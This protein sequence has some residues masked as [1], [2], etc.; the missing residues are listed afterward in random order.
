MLGNPKATIAL[1]DNGAD[2]TVSDS[3]GVCPLHWLFMFPD[4]VIPAMAKRL[5]IQKDAKVSSKESFQK[6]FNTSFA[7]NYEAA[8]NTAW[9]HMRIRLESS[10]I[11]GWGNAMGDENRGWLNEFQAARDTFL[12]K[13]RDK[14]KESFN[15]SWNEI[16][17]EP[18]MKEFNTIFED[19]LPAAAKKSNIS[20]TTKFSFSIDPQLPIGLTGTPLAFATMARSAPTVRALLDLGASPHCS[21]H[22]CSPGPCCRASAWY[23]AC[24][25]HMTDI[26]RIFIENNTLDNVNKLGPGSEFDKPLDKLQAMFA[27]FKFS[28]EAIY[29]ETKATQLFHHGAMTRDAAKETAKIL[30]HHFLPHVES[31]ATYDLNECQVEMDVDA[32]KSVTLPRILEQLCHPTIRSGNI[33]AIHTILSII[34]EY[35]QD[36]PFKREDLDNLFFLCTDVACSSSFSW[37]DTLAVLQVGLDLGVDIDCSRDTPFT[38][39]P[40]NI[41]IGY[42]SLD[43]VEWFIQQGASLSAQDLEG[44]TP[45]HHMVS[46]LSASVFDRVK[47]K[48]L[49]ASVGV[50]NLHGI[51][52]LQQAIISRRTEEVAILLDH[53]VRSNIETDYQSLL[54]T[55]AGI[56]KDF[57]AVPLVLTH[58]AKANKASTLC[59]API[60]EIAVSKNSCD[61]IQTLLDVG[62]DIHAIHS[63]GLSFFHHAVGEGRAEVTKAFLQSG[64]VCVDQLC[65]DLAA[66]QQA[67]ITSIGS[68]RT[69]T[70]R[71]RVRECTELLIN[72]GLDLNLKGQYGTTILKSLVRWPHGDDRTSLLK[73]M[74]IKGANPHAEGEDGNSLFQKAIAAADFELTQCLL[75]SQPQEYVNGHRQTLLHIIAA[76]TPNHGVT[77]KKQAD[78]LYHIVQKVVLRGTNP[79]LV[80]NSGCTAMEVAV[81]SNND[82]LC[83]IFLQTS[84]KLIDGNSS[85]DWQSLYMT[86]ID[87]AWR[88]AI[89][90]ALWG[91]VCAFI[92]NGFKG[93]LAP[94]DPAHAVKL[95]E[96]AIVRKKSEVFLQLLG[97]A[98]GKVPELDFVC[99]DPHMSTAWDRIRVDLG[100]DFR[101]RRLFKTEKIVATSPSGLKMRDKPA[102]RI[103]RLSSGQELRFPVRSSSNF[104]E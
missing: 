13:M 63:S 57:E 53:F 40:I 51:T 72:A 79:F 98:D 12:Q 97:H 39:R 16:F 33:E 60:L 90:F 10:L 26:L 91:P 5:Y 77:S 94:I 92:E 21:G 85:K 56:D 37:H 70:G 86:L 101:L 9:K 73:Q 58:A 36:I 3:N 100:M 45:V 15:P 32:T 6:V 78:A 67:V 49:V 52:P 99:K 20:P 48:N 44:N 66:L 68:K 23:I 17:G 80:D 74:I 71:S 96:Y 46:T 69:E 88:R 42:Q 64:T 25:L 47:L 95:F 31:L 75:D 2:P 87:R 65:S 84:R 34:R 54:Q 14:V 29:A 81:L 62:A 43:V 27:L 50:Q 35:A 30:F 41:A 19:S 102:E 11:E 18:R 28:S 103:I 82:S 4:S 59:L 61:V 104:A 55:A 89:E 24:A 93:S 38:R 22:L 7:D 8:V 76:N 1:L 83:S